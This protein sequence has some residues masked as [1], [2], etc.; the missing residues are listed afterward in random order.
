M[1]RTIHKQARVEFGEWEADVDAKLA[2]LIL[3]IWKAGWQTAR[4]CQR[5]SESRKVWIEF[6]YASGA[7]AFLSVMAFDHPDGFTP[8]LRRFG[9]GQW[10]SG[11]GLSEG[12]VLALR[13]AWEYHVTP[14]DMELYGQ[15]EDAST[16]VRGIALGISVLFPMK[17]LPGVLARM[18]AFNGASGDGLFRVLAERLGGQ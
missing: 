15:G 13:A 7:E 2:P 3:E 5:H 9:F 1:T 10:W 16:V 11:L 4:S 14:G 6:L 17:D 18:E 8:E 12:D